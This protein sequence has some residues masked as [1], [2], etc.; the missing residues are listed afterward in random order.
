VT[1][2]GTVAIQGR[3]E[4]VGYPVLGLAVLIEDVSHE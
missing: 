1:E 3:H 2:Q 4:R